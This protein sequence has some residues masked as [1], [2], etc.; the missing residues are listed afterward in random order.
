[1]SGMNPSPA[2][3][4]LAISASAAGCC[5]PSAFH[6]IVTLFRTVPE[7]HAMPT[8]GLERDFGSDIGDC[9]GCI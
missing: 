2:Y 5:I 4:G 3:I 6:R 7:A 1:M 9:T 8:G